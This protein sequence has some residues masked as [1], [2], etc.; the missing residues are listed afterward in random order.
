MT[1]LQLVDHS[2]GLLVSER[3][4]L[5]LSAERAASG[6]LQPSLQAGGTV[7]VAATICQLGFTKHVRA[8]E[9]DERLGWL[10]HKRVVVSTAAGVQGVVHGER[11]RLGCVR[12]R[13]KKYS[14]FP[15]NVFKE[16]I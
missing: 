7:V 6:V 2:L 9:A 15:G 4:E 10:L 13:T 12:C 11:L 5:S 1:H 16:T 3:V 14:V 8:Y